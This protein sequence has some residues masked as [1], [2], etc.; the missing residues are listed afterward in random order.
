M[1]LADAKFFG[2][3]IE[4]SEH[5][6]SDDYTL[7]VLNFDNFSY[8]W[9]KDGIAIVGETGHEL[10]R[11]HGDGSYQVRTIE[12]GNCRLSDPFLYSRPVD[13]V[14]SSQSICDD[15][16]FQF[17][18]QLLT[19]SG[20]YID[21]FTSIDN[22]DSIVM[23]DLEVIGSVFDTLAL[24]LF[25]G[26]TVN[27]EGNIIG[28]EGTFPVVLESSLGCDSLLMV[29][30]A[31]SDVYI[32]NVFYPLSA[33]GNDVFRPV[34]ADDLNGVVKMQIYDRFGGRV[35]VGTEWNGDDYPAGV[36]MYRIDVDFSPGNPET[37]YGSITLIR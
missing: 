17:G 22:C 36:Y 27:I 23:L 28:G 10:S 20:M 6:C 11:I 24:S 25:Q 16:Q 3:N 33:V 31:Y 1:I 15:D 32:P 21:T 34:I 35:Y 8:Q 18:D 26:Q 4:D 5:P 19:Q 30:I 7:S 12:D 37:F 14:P 9:Y 29:E 13:I 2:L